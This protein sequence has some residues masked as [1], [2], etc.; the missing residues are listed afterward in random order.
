MPAIVYEDEVIIP[1][2]IDDLESFRKWTYRDDFPGSGRIDYINGNIEIDMSPEQLFAH[3]RLKTELVAVLTQTVARSQWMV[4]SDSTRIA[5]MH[6]DLSAEPDVVLISK[7]AIQ[8]RR[9]Q[10]IPKA[11]R[12][13]DYIEIEGPPELVVEIVSD[14]SVRKDLRRL[15]PTY[16]SA[17]IEEYWIADARGDELFFVI[18]Q[19]GGKSFEPVAVD[20]EGW[21]T[22]SVLQKSFRLRRPVVEPEWVE[23]ELETN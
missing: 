13:N 16:F 20:Q 7:Q 15:P 14:S 1:D 22:S 17:G 21:Q 6:A 8:S 4:L 23:F 11:N 18:H 9:V 10:L 19:R 2:G 3:G 5:S 12:P